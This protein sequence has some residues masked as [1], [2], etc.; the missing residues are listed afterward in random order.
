MTGTEDDPSAGGAPLV[1]L[2]T[3][4][5]LPE[6]ADDDRL[7]LDELRILGVR[8]MP[9]V[10]DDPA[11]DWSAA[12]VA[13][14]RSTWDYHLRHKQF[15]EWVER[16]GA[17]TDL[18]NPPDTVRWNGHKGYL[19]DLEVKGVPIVPTVW[20]AA[21]SDASLAEIMSGRGWARAVV[22]PA[23]S[24]S[25]YETWQVRAENTFKA[26]RRL[27]LLLVERDMMVQPFMPSVENPG[28]RSL[29]FVE[30]QHT[31][32]VRRSAPFEAGVGEMAE[33]RPVEA[34]ADE[35]ALAYKVLHV[36]GKLTLY[37]RVDLARDEEGTSRLMELEL[38][39]PSLFLG[40]APPAARMLAAAIA[41]RAR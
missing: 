16:A 28:E 11:V 5:E 6:L 33:A 39:E 41:R 7:L 22:K 37:A 32:T 24:A 15:L 35:V 17:L 25:G 29:M 40:H 10:W 9:A 34:D 38:I 31:H 18:F 4:S 21:G 36:A 8:A 20:L 23:V 13:V 14:V 27:D 19:L 1:Y 3:Y 26:Q 2:V 30:G 12:R